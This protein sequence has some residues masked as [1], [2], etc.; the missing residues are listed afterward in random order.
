MIRLK[1]YWQYAIQDF[2]HVY[3][4]GLIHLIINPVFWIKRNLN[5]I[6]KRYHPIDS[7]IKKEYNKNRDCEEKAVLCYAP[8]KSLYFR[9]DGSAVSCCYNRFETLGKWPQEKISDIWRGKKLAKF[10]SN[11]IND[12]L[13]SGCWQCSEQLNA[14]NYNG[15]NARNFEEFYYLGNG[16]SA[17][18]LELE[19]KCN[20]ECIMCVGQFS[21]SIRKN[22]E[23]MPPLT[24]V[25]DES[26]V[27]DLEQF[28]PNVG[29]INFS[30]GEPFLIKIYYSIWKK[31]IA[32]NP[33]ITMYIQTNATILNSKIKGLLKKGNFRIG[34]SLDSVKKETY[35][36]IRVNAKFESVMNNLDYFS[37]YA[38]NKGFYLTINV[39][40]IRMNWKEIPEIINYCNLINAIVTLITVTYP[41]H[42]S[43]WNLKST[44]L[45]EIY[46]FLSSKIISDNN[47][48]ERQNKERFNAFLDQVKTWYNAALIRERN[49]FDYNKMNFNQLEEILLAKVSDK[50]FNNESQSKSQ[51]QKTLAGNL[52]NIFI[53]IESNEIHIAKKRVLI[54]LINLPIDA[55][56]ELL[57]EKSDGMMKTII[58]KYFENQA[59]NEVLFSTKNEL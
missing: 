45:I 42:V 28:L 17:I 58:K 30:G 13:P 26:F 32:T 1:T 12:D 34:I 8:F 29:K 48:I 50:I 44:E 59:I 15:V 4:L 6:S 2:K 22:R 25:Y 54:T 14:G 9:S 35:E 33:D 57:N 10:R 18:N 46:E 36:K 56:V 38:R 5:M 27:N 16:P 11:F 47:T 43:L 31:I 21:S 24:K 41:L 37:E 40:P 23:K 49:V 51:I 7:K 20:L 19:N 53:Q 52:K 3:D 39:C 55:I